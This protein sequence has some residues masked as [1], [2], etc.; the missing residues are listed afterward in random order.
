MTQS[1]APLAGACAAVVAWGLGPLFVR[2]ITASTPTIVMY[3][4]VLAVPVMITMAYLTG[5]NV[6]RV[7]MRRSF[8][9][10]VLFS[11]SM[12]TSFASFKH[13]TIVNATLIPALQPVLLVLVAG[14]LLGER[15]TRREVLWG[16][17]ALTGVM[18]V[19][20]GSHGG[21]HSLLG[22]ALAVANLCIWTVYFVGSKRIRDSGVHSWSYLACVFTWSAMLVT[23][24]ALATSSDLGSIGGTD[25]LYLLGM[26]AG[27]GLVG[28]GLMTWAQRYLDVSLASLLSLGNPVI[29]IVGA[30]IAFGQRLSMFQGL[31]ALVVLIGLGGVVASQRTPAPATIL[32]PA[33]A[34]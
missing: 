28:H 31:G 23:P 13:T 11:L 18:M 15:R 21:D 33:L 4:L 29:S 16:A 27:P 26:V 2:S 30:W 12:M 19:I 25:W 8:V 6:N 34:G 32:E 24:W 17:G 22:D 10:G 5:G 3:R 14:R 1:R 9:P 20:S 7:L